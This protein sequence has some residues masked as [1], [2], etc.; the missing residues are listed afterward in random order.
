M[1]MVLALVKYWTDFPPVHKLVAGFV[2]Y[3]AEKAKRSIKAKQDGDDAALT[4]L[5]GS[6]LE[7]GM[8]RMA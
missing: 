1:P 7:S 6:V 4:T 3:D 2:G 5:I 8:G